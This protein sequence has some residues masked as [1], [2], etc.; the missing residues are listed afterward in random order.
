MKLNYV[1]TEFHQDLIIK[2]S[3]IYAKKAFKRLISDRSNICLKNQL[4]FLRDYLIAS[5]E[6]SKQKCYCRMTKKLINVEKYK[7]LLANT[8][9]LLE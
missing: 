7:S 3:P 1:M 8:K 6:A 4:C 9:N 2:L 5:T